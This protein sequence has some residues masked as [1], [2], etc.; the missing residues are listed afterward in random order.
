MRTSLAPSSLP[1]NHAA[2]SRP[3]RGSTT[4]EAW[5]DGKGALSKMNIRVPSVGRCRRKASSGRNGCCGS[6]PRVIRRNCVTWRIWVGAEKPCRV[7]SGQSSLRGLAMSP[8]QSAQ[9]ASL[10]L[11]VI[12]R[13]G[14]LAQPPAEPMPAP[15]PVLLGPAVPPPVV[16]SQPNPYDVWQAYAPDR[17]G[18]FRPRVVLT[19]AGPFR[20][21]DGAFIPSMVINPGIVVP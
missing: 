19:P 5:Q 6:A 16:F 2:S 9:F 11:L 3:G 12:P 7:N 4:V 8:S 20:V 14:V 18:Y 15:R 17:Q 10:G 21:A 1:P 13:P